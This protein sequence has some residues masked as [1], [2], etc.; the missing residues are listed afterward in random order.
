MLPY[1]HA[2]IFMCIHVHLQ[3]MHLSHSTRHHIRN[4]HYSHD[5]TNKKTKNVTLC[6]SQIQGVGNLPPI[7][8]QIPCNLRPQRRVPASQLKEEYKRES[9]FK[10][11]PNQNQRC[12]STFVQLSIWYKKKKKHTTQQHETIL[13][14]S[15]PDEWFHKITS[16]EKLSI[17]TTH[18]CPIW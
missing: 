17:S 11:G 2:S 3:S 1:R 16:R 15:L 8:Q 12:S 14:T 7:V 5:H 10:F 4:W 18:L 9:V 6:R 13:G